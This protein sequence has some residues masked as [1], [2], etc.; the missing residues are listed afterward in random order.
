[1][2][3]EK[4]TKHHIEPWHHQTNKEYIKRLSPINKVN[5]FRNDGSK[6]PQADFKQTSLSRSILAVDR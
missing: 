2:K 5:Y 4:L 3:K 6:L 1:M